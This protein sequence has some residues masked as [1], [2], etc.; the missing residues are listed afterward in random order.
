M[1]GLIDWFV[2]DVLGIDTT[3]PNPYASGA[4]ITIHSTE[5]YLPILIGEVNNLKPVAVVF[6]GT[7][8]G[9]SDDMRN[10][11]IHKVAPIGKAVESI[12][13]ISV[14]GTDS[15]SNDWQDNKGNRWLHARR[16]PNSMNG[17]SDPLLNRAGFKS[18]YKYTD[19]ASVY[20][21]GEK[22]SEILTS[23]P[24]DIRAN[25]K[26]KQATDWLGTNSTANQR[27]TNGVLHFYN[28]L[29]NHDNGAG[30]NA[31]LLNSASWQ[32]SGN[33]CNTQVETFSGS[34]VYRDQF[35]LN[36]IIDTGKKVHEIIDDFLKALN[37]HMPYYDDQYH[38]VIEQDDNY[39]DIEIFD[40]DIDGGVQVVESADVGE[41]VNQVVIK[42]PDK[43]H[44][45]K[46][47]ELIYPEVG[48]AKD[49]QY[50]A[51]DNQ[52]RKAKTVE[53]PFCNDPFEARQI[54]KMK[55]ETSRQS[56]KANF[57]VKSRCRKLHCG[58]VVRVTYNKLGW[59]KKPFRILGKTLNRNLRSSLKL[60]EHQPYI[61]D[62]QEDSSILE[63]PDTVIDPRKIATPIDLQVGVS[64]Y[65]GMV[66]SW[67]SVFNKFDIQVE[68]VS[69]GRIIDS[70]PVSKL[71]HELINLI[72]GREYLFAV[73]ARNNVGQ[74]SDWVESEPFTFS[75]SSTS[76]NIPSNPITPEVEV[77]AVTDPELVDQY[78]WK[79]YYSIT[80]HGPSPNL[81]NAFY[82]GLLSYATGQVFRI[83]DALPN[84]TY[85]VWFGLIKKEQSSEDPTQW[86]KRSVVSGSGIS[87]QFLSDE[88]RAALESTAEIN[89][90]QSDVDD[91]IE[92]LIWRT[93]ESQSNTTKTVK[94][95]IKIERV[96]EAIANESEA[97]V[98]QGEQLTASIETEQGRVDSA[99]TRIDQVE[100]DANG[101]TA[102]ISAL[103]GTVND[104][105]NG[106]GAAYALAQLA[107]TTADGASSSISSISGQVN[108]ADT[109]L[110]ATYSIAQQAKSDAE[111]N[112]S[113]ITTI[114]NDLS[115]TDSTATA[116]LN[117]AT[118]VDNRTGNLASFGLYTNVNGYISGLFNQNDGSTSA[119]AFQ[120]DDLE[121]YDGTGA[122][123]LSRNSTT[124]KFEFRGT[125]YVE[126]LEGDVVDGAVKSTTQQI[127][128]NELG[129]RTILTFYVSQQPF[130]RIV[131]VSPV[132]IEAGNIPFWKVNF[133]AAGSVVDSWT[134]STSGMNFFTSKMLTYILP[135][136]T[137]RTFTVSVE[138]TSSGNGICQS[139]NLEIKA[140]KKGSTI[141]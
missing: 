51:E 3:P 116:A 78:V 22:G 46:N 36:G 115:N 38:L 122:V 57:D 99:L 13:S 4:D 66:A 74:F 67:N 24:N 11:L 52:Q 86:I 15:E 134:Y 32:H 87:S 104:P 106:V 119:L 95:N 102:T 83:S 62:P 94:S 81:T 93:A 135:A 31:M 20:V 8:D 85:Y 121:F 21:R 114:T 39:A 72:D 96:D 129:V 2:E 58:Q 65:G 100:S 12:V 49:L 17:Y 77:P 79:V 123:Y 18:Y 73:R 26:G 136:N 53:L 117:L 59:D 113:S 44:N 10:D 137:S 75:A 55:L 108:H 125:V 35:T 127:W 16:F 89:V 131:N 6:A 92:S 101:N 88:V 91:L 71:S 33:V 90:I 126:E 34:G 41:K 130:E 124:G 7:S 14:D 61:Y 63:I 98:T 37:A 141:T 19:C 28:Y 56:L 23:E 84:L 47:I 50:L 132:Y 128:S 103:S 25:V 120:S 9:D 110:S 111:G 43:S 118:I 42:Y 139:Q 112:A 45:G 54:A 107:K 40:E 1:G 48:S 105:I 30:W 82:G 68:Q 109:G 64:T 140:Y 76:P 138:P 97:R 70:K 69:N 29:V 133:H 60:R 27:Y 80:D 5:A